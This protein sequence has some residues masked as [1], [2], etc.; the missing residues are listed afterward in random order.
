MLF[1]ANAR[2]W[3]CRI[4]DFV[5]NGI[6]YTMRSKAMS[7]CVN[8]CVQHGKVFREMNSPMKP[9]YVHVHVF[10]RSSFSF[11]LY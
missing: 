6:G 3:Q 8:T 4:I 10:T 11:V 7:M 9:L 2:F 5:T 1:A